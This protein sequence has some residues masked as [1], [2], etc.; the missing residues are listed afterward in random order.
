MRPWSDGAAIALTLLASLLLHAAHLPVTAPEWLGWL[1]P[2]WVLLA[3]FF[4]TL[5]TPRLLS[6]SLAWLLGFAVD[7]LNSDPFG[8]QGAIFV[9]ATFVVTQFRHQLRT[10]PLLLQ[11]AAVAM[12]VFAAELVGQFARNIALGQ[13][14]SP[15]LWGSPLASALLWPFASILVRGRRHQ[16]LAQ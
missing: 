1:R 14:Y 12:L 11:I 8:L 16:Y 3:L 6:L 9:L 5:A 10:Y 2:H 13:P 7:A 15:A 4:W